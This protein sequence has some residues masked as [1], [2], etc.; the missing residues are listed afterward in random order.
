MQ[1]PPEAFKKRE[2]EL[3]PEQR[4]PPDYNWNPDYPGTLKPGSVP[5]NFPL[6]KVLESDV[7]K[8]MVYQELDI[9]ERDGEI[10]PLEEDLLEWMAKEGRLMS[11]G[12]D[13]EDGDGDVDKQITGITEEDLDYGEDDSR[14]IAYYSK[15]GEG[16]TAGASSDFGGFAESTGDLDGGF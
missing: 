3:S 1:L 7:Y 16:N 9:D 11:R 13:E 14:M 4:G 2:P 6:E 15:Q 5:D 12:S 10:F 8:N